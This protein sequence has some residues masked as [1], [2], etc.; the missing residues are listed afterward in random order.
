[1]SNIVITG[2]TGQDGGY[3]AKLLIDNGHNV[4]GI[5]RPNLN[6]LYDF[7]LKSLG[8]R[9]KV[10]LTEI[11]LLHDFNFGELLEQYQVDAV[12]HLAAQSS[13]GYSFQH[14]HRTIKDNFNLTVNLLE[15]VRLSGRNI[16]FYNSVSSEIYGNQHQLPITESTQ[17]APLSPYALSKAFSYQ[18]GQYYRKAYNMF[19]CNGILFN[20]E[21]ELRRGN[22]FINKIITE[23]ILIKKGLQDKI[24][25][26]NLNIKRDFGYAP[27]YVYAMLLMMMQKTSD[28]YIVCSGNSLLLSDILEYVLFKLHIPSSVI[29][30][31][32]NLIRQDEIY[33]IYGDNDKI[34]SIGWSNSQDFFQV[35]DKIISYKLSKE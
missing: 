11:D 28:D 7:N 15:Q 13:V 25:V 19:V 20:H 22:F 24:T 33:E 29:T 14:P 23:S 1:M 6:S 18:T 10:R 34:R 3:L 30:I 12:Y 17:L 9:D 21:S 4:I 8:V 5:T 26:G 2:I 27:D 16:K 35:L 32:S 31:D